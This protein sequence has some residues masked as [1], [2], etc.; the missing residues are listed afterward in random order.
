MN[1]RKEEE[2]KNPLKQI[3]KTIAWKDFFCFHFWEKRIGLIWI[4]IDLNF[5]VIPI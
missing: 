1:A 2:K 4:L 3:S 5:D